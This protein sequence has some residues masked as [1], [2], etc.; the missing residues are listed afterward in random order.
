M[1]GRRYPRILG[2]VNTLL[3]WILWTCFAFIA[4]TF[5]ATIFLVPGGGPKSGEGWVFLVCT[6]TLAIVYTLDELIAAVRPPLPAPPP[7]IPKPVAPKA[8]PPPVPTG[9][10]T[11]P[12]GRVPDDRINIDEWDIP[13]VKGP[14]K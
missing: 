10:L 14:K 13:V 4:I 1:D 3:R 5:V 2:F 9:P 8:E 12:V 7:R 6:C 11:R